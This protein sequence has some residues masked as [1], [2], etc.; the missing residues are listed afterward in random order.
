MDMKLIS[1]EMVLS[2]KYSIT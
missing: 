2:T 1:Q